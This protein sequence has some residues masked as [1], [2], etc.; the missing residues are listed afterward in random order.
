MAAIQNEVRLA[1]LKRERL[2]LERKDAP[3]IQT[4][5]KSDV[6][7]DRIGN[8]RTNGELANVP[9][10]SEH[11]WQQSGTKTDL[12]CRNG[13]DLTWD[14]PMIQTRRKSDAAADAKRQRTDKWRPC[15]RAPCIRTPMAA[16]WNECRLAELKLKLD[17]TIT[18]TGGHSNTVRRSK[19]EQQRGS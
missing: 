2:D 16:I 19:H 4:R 18:S 17:R 15:R 11:R 7:A 14:A 6:A 3:M 1:V 12:P 13:S 10:A 9:Q 5:R 8:V